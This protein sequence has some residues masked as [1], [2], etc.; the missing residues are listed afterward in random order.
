MCTSEKISKDNL[1]GYRE[2][3][4]EDTQY[5]NLQG[6]PLLEDRSG[7]RIS[8]YIPL[9]RVYIRIQAIEEK[10]SLAQQR[11]EERQLEN[12]QRPEYEYRQ[13][14]YFD[15]IHE[16][17]EHLYRQAQIYQKTERPEAVDPLEALKKHKRMV[18]LG[19]PG[20]GKSTLLRYVARK[21]VQ[22]NTNIPILIPLREY[23]A[24]LRDETIP[25]DDFALKQM[26]KENGDLHQLLKDA[27]EA[28]HVL[29]LLDAL[30]EAQPWGEKITR[31]VRELKG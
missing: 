31:Q 24:V 7:R 20:S 26:S 9:D 21:A 11:A 10:Q 17:G 2:H 30:D 5:I 15:Y 25:L 18:I 6:M 12:G 29:W 13:K 8:M 22:D 14:G 3:I 27:I 16:L 19:A 23:A 4:L 28:G 1:A